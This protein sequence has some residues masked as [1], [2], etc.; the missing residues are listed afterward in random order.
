MAQVAHI[1]RCAAK[2]DCSI[3]IRG[4]SGTGKEK[5]AQAIHNLSNRRL[6][7][8]VGINVSSITETL[9][10]SEM[11]GHIK[12]SFT[13]AT[14]DKKGLITSAH[15]GTLFLDEIGELSPSIQAKLL[16]VL[17]ERKVTPVGSTKSLD[18]D[19]RVISATHVNLEKAI[20]EGRFREDLY[21]RLHVMPI[22]IPAL[23]ERKADIAPLIS[24][25]LKIYNG[26]KLEILK[27]TVRSLEAYNWPGNVRELQ[28]EIE[29]IVALRKTRICPEDLNSKIRNVF[30]I[31]TDDVQDYQKFMKSQYELELEFINKMIHKGG[32]LREACRSILNASPSTI[33]T[34]VKILEK[35]INVLGYK[36][37][38]GTNEKTISSH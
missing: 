27:K 11:F 14:T 19:I 32:G 16:R 24:H 18:V 10:E 9:F 31:D 23:R 17:Q 28:N 20:S 1:V 3:F 34:R 22:K 37:Q 8:F 15:Q 12:G 33:S 5:I 29:R 35:N 25:F 6:K 30:K 21:Y 7:P 4:E 2:S 38:G 13:G 26:E 36:S